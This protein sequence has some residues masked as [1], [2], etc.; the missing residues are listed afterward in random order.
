[1][2]A[3]L[4]DAK[5]G[6]RSRDAENESL[7]SQLARQ[8]ALIN[9]LQER[10]K[11]SEAREKQLQANSETNHHTFHREKK[12]FEEQTKDLTAK[13]RHLEHDLQVQKNCTDDVKYEK[14]IFRN[15]IEITNDLFFN[16]KHFDGFVRKLGHA[17]GLEAVDA[18]HPTPECV[19]SKAND[20]MGELH[21][22]RHKL[23]A[24]SESLNGCESEYHTLKSHSSAERAKLLSQIETLQAHNEGINNRCR[25]L[26]K[27]LHITKDR[28]TE[29]EVT[30]D[31]L[32]GKYHP[33][34]GRLNLK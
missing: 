15:D 10:L 32:K 5:H 19:I 28:F 29:S 23:A 18:K 7:K 27:D 14:Y 16:R 1:M 2:M 30:G 3:E 31:K 26:E 20:L 13:I 34:N 8:S 12:L 24:T 33:F 25:S 6:I 21:R 17:L 22:L 9:S 4:Q 11:V